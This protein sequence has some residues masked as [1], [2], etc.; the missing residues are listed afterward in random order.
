[1]GDGY[2]RKQ[3]E[4]YVEERKLKNVFFGGLKNQTELP[5]YYAIADIFVL[6]SGLG[7]TWGLVVNEAMNFELP[8]IVSDLVGC[9]QDLVKNGR[10]GFVFETGDIAQ[11]A[12]FLEMLIESPE[13]RKALGRESLK[14][15][16]SYSYE[17]TIGG[18]LEG[19]RCF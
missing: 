6:P 17:K 7:E 8:V 9:W 15:I 16:E 4:A 18:I 3:L 1:V 13:T 19:S 10:N 5:Y 2:L 14:I 12:G 11:L